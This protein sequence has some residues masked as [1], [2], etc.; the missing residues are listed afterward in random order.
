MKRTIPV[1]SLI[2]LLALCASGCATNKI[3]GRSQASVVSDA[4]AARQSAQAYSQVL[5]EAKQGDAL[6]A[7]PKTVAQVRA[8]AKPIIA[9]ARDLRPET[10]NWRWD[11]HV[12]QSDEINAWCMAGGKIAVYTGLLDQIK[13]TDDELAQVLGHEISHALLSHQAEKL[14]RAMIQETGMSLIVAGAAIAGYNLGSY[15]KLA[16]ALASVGLQL[17]NSREAETEA[18]NYGIELAAKAGYN[19]NAAVTLWQKMIAA[20]GDSGASDWLSTHPGAETRIQNLQ[21]RAVRLMPVYEAARASATP[22]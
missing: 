20:T 12:L 10:R 3:T 13:P 11:V 2:V 17:P 7:D 16:N 1:S 5:T 14:S 18:D 6:D 15:A 8:I 21:A 9:K 19:P 22:R 4:E